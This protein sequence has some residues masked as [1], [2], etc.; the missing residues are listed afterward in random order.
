M[1]QPSAAQSSF[2]FIRLEDFHNANHLESNVLPANWRFAPG[3]TPSGTESRVEGPKW[4][5]QANRTLP[6]ERFPTSNLKSCCSA[7]GKW[8]RTRSAFI[9]WINPQSHLHGPRR[10]PTNSQRPRFRTFPSETDGRSERARLGF[11]WTDSLVGSCPDRRL[12][13]RVCSGPLAA[14]SVVMPPKVKSN[15]I[16]TGVRR[17][18]APA[19]SEKH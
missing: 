17:S 9:P 10:Y 15:K 16:P 4:Q 1:R 6:I 2:I 11:P 7:L 8:C 5:P 12:R 13:C 18:S 14:P 19:H 3:P